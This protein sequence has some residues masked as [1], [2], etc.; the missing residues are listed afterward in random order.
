[1]IIFLVEKKN[2]MRNCAFPKPSTYDLINF[3][4]SPL[5]LSLG[6]DEC[7]GSRLGNCPGRVRGRL[8]C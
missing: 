2:G 3:E 7:S 6:S 1:M 8:S 5:G 4:P